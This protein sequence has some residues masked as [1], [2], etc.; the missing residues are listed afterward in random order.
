M[1]GTLDGT[2]DGA[3]D[4]PLEGTGDGMT[5]RTCN[6]TGDG[7]TDGPQDGTG[8]GTTVEVKGAGD[9]WGDGIVNEKPV[10][11]V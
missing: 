8:D 9:E 4:S 2:G 7:A 6:S 3:T 5:D 10:S 1:D 11:L